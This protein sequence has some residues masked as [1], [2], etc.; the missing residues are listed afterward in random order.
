MIF[1]TWS[2]E[3]EKDRKRKIRKPFAKIQNK[4]KIHTRASTVSDFLLFGCDAS[5]TFHIEMLE[6]LN[7]VYFSWIYPELTIPN[8]DVKGSDFK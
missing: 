8:P 1:S 7:G 2:N 6:I 3:G 4:D 5:L